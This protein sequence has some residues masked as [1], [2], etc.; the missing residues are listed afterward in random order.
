[1]T[2]DIALPTPE[3]VDFKL[4][5]KVGDRYL[6]RDGKEIRIV[7][8]DMVSADG[9]RVAGLVILDGE[10]KFVQ[11]GPLGNSNAASGYDLMA[12]LTGFWN[13]DPRFPGVYF[14]SSLGKSSN[15]GWRHWDGK[16]WSVSF[17]E[18]ADAA[19]EANKSRKSSRKIPLRW[20]NSK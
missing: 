1:M 15:S 8:T 13:G 5:I 4:P 17:V 18:R 11:F 12:R 20:K 14:T 6:S 2:L 3:R 10:E 19:K 9:H 7:C 16:S